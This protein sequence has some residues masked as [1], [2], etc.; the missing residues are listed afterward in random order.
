MKTR[1]VYAILSFIP[2]SFLLVACSQEDIALYNGCKSGIFIQEVY[3][4]DFY[5]NPTSYRD[6]TSYSFAEAA[7][8][9]TSGYVRFYVRTIGEL[10]DFDRPYSLKVS[11]AESTAVE[12]EDFDF[13]GNDFTIRANQNADTVWVRL[14]R[15]NKLRNITLRI[16]LLIE[17]NDYFEVPFDSY[18]NSVKWNVDGPKNSASSYLIK[19]DEKYSEPW[20]WSWFCDDENYFGAFTVARYLEVNKVMGW[21]RDDWDNAGS[22]GAKVALGKFDF[23][24]RALQ[25]HL[26]SMA[27]AGTPVLD[28]DGSYMQL[29]FEYQVDYSHIGSKE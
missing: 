8:T 28:D 1:I 7:E 26:Q 12:G 13:E 10:V 2:M 23:A 27:D 3:S 18:K 5:G 25:K 16:K 9:V 11:S 21:T 29:P 20:Y 17:P 6:S 4:T 22:S 19:F 24:S 14:K 15:S